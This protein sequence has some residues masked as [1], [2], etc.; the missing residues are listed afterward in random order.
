M[1]RQKSFKTTFRESPPQ[2]KKESRTKLLANI[3]NIAYKS[4]ENRPLEYMGYNYNPR[5]SSEETAV[6]TRPMGSE[7]GEAIIAFRGTSDFARDIPTDIT[8]VFGGKRKDDP[9]FYEAQRLA[10]TVSKK[11]D[12]VV[13]GHSLGGSLATHAVKVNPN[14]NLRAEVFNPGSGIPELLDNASNNSSVRVNTTD[15]DIVSMLYK[16]PKNVRKQIAGNAHTI[17]NFIE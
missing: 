11:Y 15:N 7:R 4:P 16:G 1:N 13:T 5:Y 14:A 9:R 3:S 10:R 12:T 6:Y 17:L 2:Q 8:G